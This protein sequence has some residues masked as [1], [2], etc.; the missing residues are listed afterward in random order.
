MPASSV[1]LGRNDCLC[2]SCV[3][4]RFGESVGLGLQ[5]GRR[6]TTCRIDPGLAEHVGQL[7]SG[8]VPSVAS[9]DP[10]ASWLGSGI[11]EVRVSHFRNRRL[12][13]GR[14]DTDRA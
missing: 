6:S 11:C 8:A 12:G 4:V 1:C 2:R 7:G 13:S 9:D 14:K 10:L 3:F 5:P